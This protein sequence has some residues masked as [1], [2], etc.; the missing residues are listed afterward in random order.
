[1]P[2]I[3]VAA[4]CVLAWGSLVEA[5]TPADWIVS[6][7][8]SV[9]AADPDPEEP[10][11]NLDG[12]TVRQRVRLSVGGERVRVRLSNEFG[13]A[14][15]TVGAA[16]IAVAIDASGIKPESLRVLKF[17]GRG[18]VTI[19][20]GAPALSDP[21]DLVVEPG[22][23]LT[24][25][26]YFPGRVATPTLHGLALKRTVVTAR[27]DFTDAERIEAH[28]ISQSFLALGAVLVPRHGRQRLVVAFGDS[29]TDGDGST[30]EADAAWP[31][32]LIRRLNARRGGPRIAVV[33]Q[34]IAGNRL[35][36]NGFGI[37][38]LG[39]SGLARFDRDV[40]AL[41]GVTHVVLLEGLNDLGFAGAT[42]GGQPLAAADETFQAQDLI[43]GYRQLIARAHARGV[44]IIGATLT[45]FA[46]VVDVPGYYS[47]AK[48]R[49]RQAVNDWIRTSGA[50]D[51][52]VDF[53]AVVRDPANHRRL[54]ARYASADGLHPNDAGYQA[55][56]D[57]IDL[58]LF[59]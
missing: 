5:S 8:T 49:A 1:M 21:V 32:A 57:A 22:A 50:F 28:A 34:G 13:S 27:G 42:L 46:G 12:Q 43:E 44:K 35:L 18:S 25:S 38:A 53:D 41:P 17:S 55:M 59:D 23:G 37:N 9:H 36:R 10:L 4:L 19:P 52:I 16:S 39:Q 33:N 6:W 40:L 54:I 45:P 3:L 31:S 47:P 14:P 26:L 11:L 15:L 24:V 56:A 48:E 30:I 2:R 7:A 29:I 20:P 51:G 58:A